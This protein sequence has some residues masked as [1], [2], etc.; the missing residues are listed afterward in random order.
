MH[1]YAHD[2]GQDARRADAARLRGREGPE[3]ASESLICLRVTLFIYIPLISLH[4][5]KYYPF[6]FRGR[7]GPEQASESLVVV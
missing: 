6:S 3:Q 5:Y 2:E 1:T 4:K 7:E